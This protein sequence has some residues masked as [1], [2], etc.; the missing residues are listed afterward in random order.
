MTDSPSQETTRIYFQNING[1]RWDAEAGKWPY[2]CEVLESINADIACFVETNTNTNNYTV[3]QK[4]ETIC[5]LQFQQSRLILA[6]SNQSSKSTYKPGG[7]ALLARNAI[8][9]RIKSHTRDRMGRWASIS[10]DASPTKR[11]RIITAYQVGTTTR[12]GTNTAAA[13]QQAQIMIEQSVERQYQRRTPR[14][15]FIHD[16]QSFIRQV[17]N[18][19]EEIILLG[20][21]NEE[22]SSPTSGMDRLATNCGLADLFSIR[23]GT[24]SG[25]ATYQRGPRRIDYALVSPTLLEH[26]IAA[27][28][29]PFGYRI[30]TD[31]RAFYIDFAPVG[32]EVA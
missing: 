15:A 9:A 12:P 32:E 16:L 23:L 20:D 27:G 26:V 14:E 1:L 8:T 13:Q 3:R 7:T 10:I 25:P 17:Q 30:P 11:I 29:D 5:Q 22:I 6:S 31:H 2:I 19:R 4:M 24:T 28:Y 18:E 21:F